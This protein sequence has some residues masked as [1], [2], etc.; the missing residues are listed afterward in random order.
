MA[1]SASASGSTGCPSWCND[2]LS[3]S[4][5]YAGEEV[6]FD[7]HSGD[8]F[9]IWPRHGEEWTFWLRLSRVD[10]TRPGLLPARTAPTIVLAEHG[11]VYDGRTI[12]ATEARGL[13]AALLRCADAVEA[14]LT[15]ACSGCGAA[16]EP[17]DASGC[18]GCR[19][20]K[21]R[22]QLVQDGAR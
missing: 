22:L 6:H 19:M 5:D 21:P 8:V 16:V 18:A 1:T 2:H 9:S 15:D 3:R 10:I 14:E 13:A 11:S 7:A 4:E 12:S 17:V 20:A